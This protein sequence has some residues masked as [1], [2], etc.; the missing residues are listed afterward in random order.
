[1]E[2]AQI[3]KDLGRDDLLFFIG[4]YNNYIVDFDYENSGEPVCAYEFFD[5]EFQMILEEQ[6]EENGLS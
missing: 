2:T 1:M 6:A 3:I 5:N 4:E